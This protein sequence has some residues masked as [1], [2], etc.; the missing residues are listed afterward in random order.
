[1]SNRLKELRTKRG[2]QVTA[3]RA[4]LDK[5]ATEK[6]DLSAEEQAS[7]EAMDADQEKLGKQVEREEKQSALESQM[8]AIATQIEPTGPSNPKGSEGEDRGPRASQ[9][10]RTAF[11]RF[12]K[13]GAIAGPLASLQAD[14][15]SAGGFLLTP[16]AMVDTLLKTID[17]SVF[18]R[19]LA[20]KFRVEK[21]ESLG[22]PSLDA[23]PADADWT[24]E[25]A[26]GNEDS[27]M[28]IGRR[29]L[30]PHPLAKRIKVS[31]K[32][33]RLSTGGAEALVAQRLAYKFAVSEEKAFLTGDGASKPLG[34]F[35]AHASGITTARDVST[36][37]S[38]TAIGADGLIE[39]KY[40]LKEGYQK[41][42]WWIFHRDAV[43]A[44]RKLKDAQNQY[45]W[46]PGLQ[47]GQPDRILDRPFGMSEY[48]PNTFTTG[49]YVGI[50]GDMSYFWIADALGFDLQRLN[51]LY[52]ETN[53]VGFIG[54]QEVDGMPALAEAFARV[55]LA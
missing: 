2:Q 51:E 34:L 40:A 27:T 12:L 55:T 30:H 21:A 46:Q 54:R 53:Q 52:A 4:L 33:L 24:S 8:G 45:L 11:E 16:L 6:R 47:G 19:Q 10:Y 37:N 28:A 22:A 48:A 39:A 3:M 9:E 29:E 49:K 43:K 32:L 23:D 38:S 41:N 14:N 18:I 13:T 20:T 42:A 17:D 35:T 26:T 5:A 44:I 25:I 15:D 50:I 36:G 31:R 1:M 7:Y